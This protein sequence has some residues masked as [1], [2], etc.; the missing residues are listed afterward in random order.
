MQHF[1]IPAA[2]AAPFNACADMGLKVSGMDSDPIAVMI[3]K[4]NLILAGATEYPD[5]R[6]TDF[7]SRWKSER[8]RFD[9]AAT[10]PP[11]SSKLKRLCR[12]LE[13]FLHENALA[14]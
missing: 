12:C 13:L 1:W 7:V 6:V 4:A 2:A 3:A 9:F 11:W 5:V 10:N 14:P 8:R